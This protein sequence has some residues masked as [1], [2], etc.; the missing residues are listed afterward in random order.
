MSQRSPLAKKLADE[1]GMFIKHKGGDGGR[2]AKQDIENY[3]DIKPL[4]S[5]SKKQEITYHYLF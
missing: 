3:S 4:E 1:K 2:I 5:E